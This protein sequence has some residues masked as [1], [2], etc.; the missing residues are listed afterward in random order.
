MIFFRFV[1][2]VFSVG[3]VQSMERQKGFTM[4]LSK[5]EELLLIA[6]LQELAREQV[7]LADEGRVAS[8]YDRYA[9]GQRIGTEDVARVLSLSSIFD[10]MKSGPDLVV[11]DA[12]QAAVGRYFAAE[13]RALEKKKP[14]SIVVRLGAGLELVAS[15]LMGL[16][17]VFVAV[18]PTRRSGV[19][20][21]RR[22][23][24]NESLEGGGF[25]ECSILRSTEDTVMVSLLYQDLKEQLT[26]HLCENG[27]PIS[28]QTVREAGGRINFDGLTAGEYT[29]E[30]SGSIDRSFTL[31]LL[32][33][34]E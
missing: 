12:L 9:S 7:S 14:G 33:P 8:V 28:S 6:A 30:M 13:K 3:T 11:P 2:K 26:V 24:M 34:G 23:T 16:E 29:I 27:R 4:H 18:T 25:I 17:P 32:G 10:R 5:H 1:C 20:T 21:A 15:T 19:E 31:R 22:L